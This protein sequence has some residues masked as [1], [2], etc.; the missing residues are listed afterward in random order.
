VS[1]VVGAVF[2]LLVVAAICFI[3]AR[4]SI[5]I[6]LLITLYGVE[7]MLM[8]HLPFMIPYSALYN[9]TVGG[10]GV[11]AIV[12]AFY[13]FG[14][15]KTPAPYI[16]LVGLFFAYTC[17]SFLWTDA[18]I[19]AREWL[20]H[21]V[22]EVPLCVLVPIFA[23]RRYED[24]NAPIR[25]VLAV[26]ALVSLTL[27]VN[28]GFAFGGRTYLVG[29]ATVLS[30]A[31]MTG[32]A[33]VLLTALD[34]RVLGFFAKIRIPMAVIMALALYRS[35][36][37][38]Q[39]LL[40]LALPAFLYLS[41]RFTTGLTTAAST[42][43]AIAVA[44]IIGL[45]VV[46]LDA[47]LPTLQ[48][49]ERYSAE[50]LGEGMQMRLHFIEKSLSGE[51]PLFGHGVAGWSFMHNHSDLV[52]KLDRGRITYPHNSLAHVY[53]ELGFVGLILFA[54][55]IAVSLLQAR[56]LLRSTPRDHVAHR[57]AGALLLYFLFS[58][59]LSL[60]QNTYLA[61]LG[62]YL[63]AS[64]ITVLMVLVRQESRQV[65]LGTGNRRIQSRAIG[66]HV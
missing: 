42:V 22:A 1:A 29:M 4:P 38:G 50:S 6:G 10:A 43:L 59:G 57:I 3:P 20:T 44:A 58:F 51:N 36:A 37:R 34:R 5:A 66:Q 64:M 28:P 65:V 27:L 47:D 30:P 12:S 62:F 23:L 31:E 48:I 49:Q 25:F 33:L 39:F 32:A 40:A 9:F 15:P 17:A 8:A 14:A 46:A 21:F 24:F 54:S 7:Q 26:S 11:V 2:L 13:R 56:T 19:T 16:T 53:F 41:K 61:I 55:I 52:S 35:G 18:P 45:A 63:S 60:K